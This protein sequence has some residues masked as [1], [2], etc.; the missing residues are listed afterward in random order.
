MNSKFQTKIQ[1]LKYEVIKQLIRS[2]DNGD[3]RNIYMEIPKVISPGPKATMRCC[4][5]KERAVLQERL[6]LA[7]GGDRNN[8]NI[9]EVIDIACDE[10]PIDGITVTP[11]CRGCISHQCMDA[12]PKGVISFVDKRAYID[13]EKCIEC[14]RCIKA[15]PYNAIIEQR[16]PCMASC[17][18]GAISM[19]KYKKARIDNEKCIMCGAC[20]YLCP[21]GAMQDKSMI[22][23]VL[24]ILKDSG[25]SREFPVY[26]IIAPAI[27]SQFSYARIEQVV[28][29]ILKL[30]F[31]QVVEAAL[32]ADIVLHK[33]YEEFKEKDVLMTSCCPSFVMYIEKNFPNLAKHISGTVSPMVEA[34]RLIKLAHPDAKVVFIGPC[35]SKKHEYK[36]EKAQGYVDSVLSFEE[37]QAFFDAREIDIENLGELPLNNASYFGRIFAKSGGIT[38]GI[39][40]LAEKEENTNFKPVAMAS[41]DS[42]RQNMIKLN[43]GRAEENFFEGMACEGGCINGPLCLKHGAKN[44]AVVDKYARQAKESETV[45]TL[46]LYSL[47]SEKPDR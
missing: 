42:C 35:A 21:F 14:G 38:E 45:N 28:S 30:G 37:L 34:A 39:K 22:T 23:E 8:P 5:F 13:K 47:I 20:V 24:D 4:V 36:L 15:C 3:M 18:V 7:L 46:K 26:A 43:L 27:V 25:N 33:E 19:D 6:K 17:K 40:N 11:A 10:C 41:L 32:G 2:Y 12:C 16:R 44:V 29:G 1:M 9:I 31:Y